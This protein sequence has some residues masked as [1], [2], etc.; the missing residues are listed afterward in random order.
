M[1]FDLAEL[2]KMFG[3]IRYNNVKLGWQ[4]H[5]LELGEV[6]ALLH[7]EVAEMTDAYRRWGFSD[8]TRYTT[9]ELNGSV[10]GVDN[11]KPEGVGSEMADVL[12]RLLD[13]VDML[14]IGFEYLNSGHGRFGYSTRFG[15]VCNTLHTLIAKLSMALDSY[16]E[17]P[18]PG[19]LPLIGRCFRDVYQY[20]T[21]AA[22]H[23][24]IDI[25]FEYERKLEFNKT[26]A[27]R[28]GGKKM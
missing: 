24:G 26:R 19:E 7:T 5:D 20:L 13:N 21:Q 10:V 3:E 25:R 18:L 12:I 23:F 15:T 22:E 11:P 6:M 4:P 9:L 2:S 16:E 1:T 17:C 28:H 8:A 14:P 27:Y